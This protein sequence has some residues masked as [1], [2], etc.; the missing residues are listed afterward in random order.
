MMSVGKLYATPGQVCC[1]PD[2]YDGHQLLLKQIMAGSHTAMIGTPPIAALLFMSPT[3]ADYS[4]QSPAHLLVLFLSFPFLKKFVSPAPSNFI[5]IHP[6]RL[7]FL[8]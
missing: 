7:P 5:A 2:H 3:K 1:P 4:R 8:L 6:D